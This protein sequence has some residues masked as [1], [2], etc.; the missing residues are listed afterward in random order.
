MV[1]PR[2]KT[3]SDLAS[4]HPG[5]KGPFDKLTTRARR[6]S[7]RVHHGG[8]EFVEFGKAFGNYLAFVLVPADC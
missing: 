5:R 6:A 3:K 1:R 7:G 2:A 4:V 8:C